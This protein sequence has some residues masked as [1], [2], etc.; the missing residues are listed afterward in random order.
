M[1][2]RPVIL[3]DAVTPITRFPGHSLWDHS[4]F[5]SD[6]FI[7]FKNEVKESVLKAEIDPLKSSLDRL[8]NH[9]AQVIGEGFR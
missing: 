1:R 9:V 6:Q 2:L 8:P 7:R 3:Q 4:V 5:Q